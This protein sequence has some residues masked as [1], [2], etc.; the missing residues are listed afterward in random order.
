MYLIYDDL[1]CLS[2][3]ELKARI[4]DIIL[5]ITSNWPERLKC[6]PETLPAAETDSS[7]FISVIAN[8]EFFSEVRIEVFREEPIRGLMILCRAVSI[9]LWAS[10]I[11]LRL[12]AIIGIKASGILLAIRYRIAVDLI[13]N[14]LDEEPLYNLDQVMD[15]LIIPAKE[16][17]LGPA[18]LRAA[19][20]E[21]DRV[22]QN[23][24]TRE[25]FYDS[26]ERFEDNVRSQI[27]RATPSIIVEITGRMLMEGIMASEGMIRDTMGE[28]MDR[29]FFGK[30][31]DTFFRHGRRFSNERLGIKRGGRRTTEKFVW[32]DDRK[33]EF[34]DKVDGLRHKDGQPLW[35]FA[36]KEL[37]DKD[38]DYRINQWLR[39]ETDLI[40]A[41]TALW[42]KAVNAWEGQASDFRRLSA[43]E[44]PEA[45]AMSHAIHLLEFPEIAYSTMKKYF[46]QGKNVSNRKQCT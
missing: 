5:Q 21:I 27:E 34:H 45:F 23:D 24:L 40:T 18:G 2:E 10:Q 32:T 37:V 39:S 11:E 17:D 46:G 41:P 30:I 44:K 36:H 20:A 8:L 26:V 35:T 9:L 1:S 29:E 43:E 14:V 19:E 13:E 25:R 22:V 12:L 42:N 33:R 3:P 15:C 6:D 28:T 38:F 4:V 7:L 31:M 16:P